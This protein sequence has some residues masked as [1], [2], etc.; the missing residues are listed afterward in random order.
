MLFSGC[1][2]TPGE[3]KLW[4]FQF[5]YADCLLPFLPPALLQSSPLSA[6]Q[7]RRMKWQDFQFHFAYCLLPIA[8]CLLLI[9]ICPLVF[10][11]SRSN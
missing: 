8:H 6:A 3:M 9:A 4:D 5:H 10:I 11:Y 1:R 7:P 2:A